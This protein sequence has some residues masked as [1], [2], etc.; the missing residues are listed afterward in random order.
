MPN[1]DFMGW[2]YAPNGFLSAEDER[3]QHAAMLNPWYESQ[4]FLEAE[5]AGLAGDE[6]YEP[7]SFGWIP[8]ELQVASA[9]AMVN[10]QLDTNQGPYQTNDPK[11]SQLI[12]GLYSSAA[13]LWQDIY[14]IDAS[15]EGW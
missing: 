9:A 3:A 14:K 13:S 2:G 7:N 8:T 1:G 10:N 6:H 11:L 12:K 15:G 5:L 4:K